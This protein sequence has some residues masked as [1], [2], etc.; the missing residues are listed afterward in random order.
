MLRWR[1]P[2]PIYLLT[3]QAQPASTRFRDGSELGLKAK[4]AEAV[5]HDPKPTS[6]MRFRH[7]AFSE[8]LAG[9]ETKRRALATVIGTGDR[10]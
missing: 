2:V 7:I 8:L 5:E 1:E 9:L 4:P 6:A 3:A 10:G